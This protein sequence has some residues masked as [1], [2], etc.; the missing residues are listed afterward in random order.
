MSQSG[1]E[2]LRGTAVGSLNERIIHLTKPDLKFVVNFELPSSFAFWNTGIH[3]RGAV[4]DSFTVC[5]L[6][7]PMLSF[8]MLSYPD[9]EVWIRK[10]N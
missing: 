7:C 1:I 3:Y 10:T 6:V 5:R 4:T 9:S 8:L 2:P